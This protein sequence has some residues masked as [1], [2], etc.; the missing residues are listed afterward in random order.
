MMSQIAT[1]STDD[2]LPAWLLKV[3]SAGREQFAT[4]GLPTG[5]EEAW[6]FT[7]IQPI[8]RTRF[9]PAEPADGSNL[10][11][12]YTVGNEAGVEIVF[13]NGHFSPELS[14]LGDLPVGVTVTTLA[15]AASGPLAELAQQHFGS[16]INV[17]KHPFG[18]E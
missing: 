3:Q 18:L 4:V 17:K 8:L 13:V 9:A 15:D 10:H 12:H 6:R 11:G 5:K 7:K 16:L 1:N 14:K 2:V